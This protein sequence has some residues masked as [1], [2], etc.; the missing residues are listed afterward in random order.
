MCVCE[1][2]VNAI[3]INHNL[4]GKTAL[5]EVCRKQTNQMALYCLSNKTIKKINCYQ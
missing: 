4:K 2:K 1:E 3:K 5:S